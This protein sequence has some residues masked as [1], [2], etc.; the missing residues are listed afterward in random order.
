MKIIG[1]VGKKWENK[2]LIEATG[3]EIAKIM[4][5]YSESNLRVTLGPGVEIEVVENWDLL[6]DIEARKKTG[7]FGPVRDALEKAIA[8]ID[9]SEHVFVEPEEEDD[10]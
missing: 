7:Y 10:E 2:F 1:T 6:T 4:G 9:R 8:E 3:G 5:S